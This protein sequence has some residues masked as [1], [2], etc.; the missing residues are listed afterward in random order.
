MTKNNL[1]KMENKIKLS[2]KNAF[3]IFLDII[4]DFDILFVKQDYYNTGDYSYFFTTER[5]TKTQELINVLKRKKSLEIAYKTLGSIK[6]LRLSFFFGIK[7]YDCFYG[8]YNEDNRYIYKVGKFRIQNKDFRK[9][10]RNK[11]M[12]T[13]RNV[14][15]K[16]NLKNM[17]ILQEIRVDFHTLFDKI[18]SNVEILDEHRIKNTFKI[19]IFKPEDRDETKL[20]VYLTQW[21]RNFK[22]SDKCYYFIQLTDKYIHFY[23]KLIKDIRTIV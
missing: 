6:E 17:K 1:L 22:W 20:R 21:S 10:Y 16:G 23:I 11:C 4:N 14:I 15:E 7:G 18:D 9:L 3:D 2:G 5:I 13:I 19:D 8:F 12:K